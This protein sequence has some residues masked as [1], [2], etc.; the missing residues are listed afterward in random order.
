[1]PDALVTALSGLS[2]QQ[3]AMEVTSHNLA[4][5]ATPGFSRQRV[6]LQSAV[7]ENTRP[8]QLGRGVQLTAVRR[9][10]DDLLGD[11]LRAALGEYGRL[12]RLGSSLRSLELAFNEPGDGGLG[13]ATSDLFAALE[14]LSSNAESGALRATVAQSLDA[15]TGNL[16]ALSERLERFDDDLRIALEAEV[17]ELNGITAEIASLNQSIRAQVNVGNNP[18]DLL[19]RRDALLERLSESISVNVRRQ[20]D[21]GVLVDVDGVGL[22]GLDA[23]TPL[24]A[25]VD[26]DGD[27]VLRLPNGSALRPAGGRAAGL[28]EVQATVL[29][30]VEADL[31]AL[32]ATMALAFNRLYSTATSHAMDAPNH[33]GSIG[34]AFA[35]GGTDLDDA[36][37]EPAIAGGDGIP[38]AFRPV[39]TDASGALIA[40]NL[41]I[42]V[43]DTATG[44]ASKHTVRFD[45]AVGGGS[46]SLADL[47]AAINTGR[48]GG[49]SLHPPTAGIA[50]LTAQ[51]VAV[52]GAYRLSLVAAAGRSIDF[53]PA[54]DVRPAAQAWAGPAFAIAGAGADPAFADTRIG[55]RASSATQLQVF[56]RDPVSGAETI[57][58]T[59]TLAAGGAVAI[60]GITLTIPATAGALRAGDQVALATTVGG[61]PPAAT[62][63]APAWGAGD[64]GFT[65]SGRYT[66]ALS[67]D[68]ARPWSARVVT[69]GVIGAKPGTAPPNN[70]PLVEFTWWD[71]QPGAEVQ[72]KLQVTLDDSRPAGTPIPIGEGVFAVFGAGSLTTAGHTAAFAPDGQADQAGLLPALGIND[73]LS[74]SLARDLRLSDS[75]AADPDRFSVGATRAAGDNSR[76]RELLGT[77]SAK[78]F[79]GGAF[80]LDD[81]YQGVI[82]GVGTRVQQTQRGLESQ[83]VLRESIEGRKASVSGVNI[84]EEVGA[85]ILQ[86]QAYAASA[87]M[88]TAA[89]ENIQTLLDILR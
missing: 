74:G 6:E 84:D 86:Q 12:D 34:I 38:T 55:V 45:P 32:A 73:A 42:N 16:R 82:A 20:D 21:G 76:V 52:D 26:A 78:L 40:R 69:T 89:R 35:Q 5:A 79:A 46:R 70:P 51:A 77:R 67:F 43:L 50:G 83:S 4:N 13:K 7:P 75:L 33:L 36:A 85:L 62:A 44:V 9:V 56:T 87:R 41:T 71:G 14:D 54:L 60:G 48:G 39:F 22:V 30:G 68:P 2:A 58:G 28:I 11:R 1:M 18:N 53:S 31:D 80:G 59:V 47:V 64:A 27:L 57:H 63:L 8:G 49:F 3:R 88:I 72:R 15:W 24:R 17:R 25:D 81:F 29:A 61:A 66:G 37:L 19:D 65:V 23:A 10:V